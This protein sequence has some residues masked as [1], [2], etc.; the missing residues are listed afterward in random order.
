[1]AEKLTRRAIRYL[2]RSVYQSFVMDSS[3]PRSLLFIFGCQRSGTTMLTGLFREDPAAIVYG[4]RGLAKPGEL[5]LRPFDEIKS[6]IDSEKALVQVCKPL[7]E[8]QHAQRILEFFPDARAIWMVRD[9]RDVVRS[10][11]R[12]FSATAG[13]RNLIPILD[14]S[15]PPTFAA[16]CVSW[17][18]RQV[19]DRLFSRESNAE[20]AQA[21][22]WYIRN[23]V[24]FEQN[25]DKNKQVRVCFY[26]DFVEDPEG[27][28]QRIYAFIGQNFPGSKIVKD[29]HSR[30]SNQNR[31]INVSSAIDNLCRELTQKFRDQGW[32]L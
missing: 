15:A 21:L 7:V 26:E 28:L 22:Y 17:E 9:Y 5:R 20:E 3:A 23:I 4:E 11:I 1:M 13:H 27:L 12:K 29:V 25:L 32:I 24:Y 2:R 18:T 6:I 10:A 8:S 16:E 31:P 19:L 30:S 14:K